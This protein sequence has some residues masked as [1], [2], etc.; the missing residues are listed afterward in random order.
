M[1]PGRMGSLPITAENPLG[2]SWHDSTWIPILNPTNVMDY[3]SQRS[4]PFF[5]EDCNNEKIKMQRLNPDL[6]K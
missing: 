3:F 6:L 5:D 4:N 1:M 2:L